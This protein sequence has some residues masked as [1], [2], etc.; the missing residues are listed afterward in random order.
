MRRLWMLGC[1]VVMVLLNLW[2]GAL[3]SGAANPKISQPAA[4]TQRYVTIDFNDVD[5]NLFIKYISNHSFIYMK[6]CKS[7]I[8]SPVLPLQKNWTFAIT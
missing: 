8:K 3:P 2:A 6:F 7:K 1:V 5:I 4:E